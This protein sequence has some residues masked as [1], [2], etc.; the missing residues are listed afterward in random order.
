MNKALMA[1]LNWRLLVEKKSLWAKVLLKKYVRGE[2]DLC[3][4]VSKQCSSNAWKGI[5]FSIEILQ[6]GSRIEVTN[7][8]HTFFWQDKWLTETR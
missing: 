1:K 4:L 7:G 3:K 2:V 8:K 6:K 5:A